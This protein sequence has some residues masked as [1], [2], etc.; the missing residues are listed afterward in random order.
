MRLG[1]KCDGGYVIGKLKANYDLY[2]SAG[3]SEEESFSKD[4]I[5]YYNMNSQNS[6]AFDGTIDDYPYQYTEK[7]SFINQ[8]INTFD[9]D[10]NSSLAF[11]FNSHC[12]NIFMKMDIEGSEYEWILATDSE[13]LKKLKQLVIEFH[14]VT[15]DSFCSFQK[16]LECFEKLNQTHYLI[17]AH[18]NNY[19]KIVYGFPDVIELTYINKQEVLEVPAFNSSPLPIPALDFPNNRHRRDI[20]LNFEPFVTPQ[21]ILGIHSYA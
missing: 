14:G 18:G 6:I 1:S 7:I 21:D 12:K 5:E 8:N 17:H 10:K 20:N 13:K 15:D 19:G 16:K 2:I 11:L 4:F 3:V 9:D